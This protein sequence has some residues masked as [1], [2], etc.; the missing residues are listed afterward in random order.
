[1]RIRYPEPGRVVVLGVPFFGAPDEEDCRAFV[2]VLLDLE[3]VREVAI[4]SRDES[5]EVRFDAA[6]S[7]ESFGRALSDRLRAPVE[8]AAPPIPMKADAHGVFRIHRSGDVFST[9]QVVSEIPGRM[10]VRNDRLFRHTKV[11]QD[12]ERELM[13]IVG[14]DRFRTSA[15]AGSLLVYYDPKKIGRNELVLL[16]DEVLL[17]AEEHPHFDSNKYELLLCSTAV[18]LAAA[19]QWVAPV[20]MVPAAA[21]FIYCVTP[22]FFAAVGV[23]F[24]ERRLGVDVLDAIVAIMCLASNQIF[25]GAVL[26]WCLAFGRRMLERAREDS[27]RRLVQV[28]AKQPRHAY[29]ITDGVELRV[30]IDSLQ[31]G[32]V[33][34]VHTGE[35]MPVDGVVFEGAAVVDQ[36]AL[37]GESV[38]VEKEPGSR[39]FASTVVVGGR[40]FVTV[41]QAGKETTSARITSILNETAMYRLA[42]QSRGEAL[43]DRAVIPTLALAV[44]AYATRGLHP[45]VA[46]IN[47]DFGTGIRM[48][49]PLALLSSLTVCANRGILVKD[50]RALEE[51]GA[52]D[53]V[54]FDKTGTLTT[55]QPTVAQ[56]HT[57]GR[58]KAPDILALAAAAERRLGHPIALAIVAA[59]EELGRPY[60]AVEESTYEIGYGVRVM[61]GKRDVRVGSTR[62]L[63]QEDIDVAPAEEIEAQAHD[64][65]HTL[66]HVAV[67]GVL[68]GSIEL[69]PTLR[70][71][72]QELIVRLREQGISQIA[73]IS[74]DHEKPTRKLGDAL[75][76]DRWF[77]E[78]LPEDKARY[79]ELLQKEGRRVCFVGDGINDAIALKR[80]NVSVS[81]RGATSVATDTAQI[82]LM[83][84]N[85]DKLCELIEIARGLERNVATS[86]QMIL[87]PN[88]ACIAGAFFLNFGVMASVVAN[89][90]AAIA[91]LANGLRP[92][93]MQSG[94]EAPTVRRE[95]KPA[96]I[97]RDL[98]A[99]GPAVRGAAAV[100]LLGAGIVG[101]VM[102]G[103]PGW[104]LIALS[105]ALLLPKRRRPK[106]LDRWLQ[107]SAPPQPQAITAGSASP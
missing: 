99:R 97:V 91:A 28:F 30:P 50:G 96:R 63:R 56:V 25:A 23:L 1:M 29:L 46:V 106:L 33:V 32:D 10:R 24:G 27:R 9:S 40:L 77:A 76:V 103:I 98:A 6:T 78:V 5:A 65:G 48:A 51:M 4:R 52:I 16:L 17:A 62:Y 86:W 22:T 44:A 61:S 79:V 90:V 26:A 85:L 49:A 47:C 3:S 42:S 53:T 20:L 59:F 12:V 93:R 2:A 64:A 75:G 80:A 43:A 87:V 92:L 69:E 70:E 39:V 14:I 95:T 38:P 35:M 21:L 54:L 36:H 84:E 89:N 60:P 67:N 73:I 104:P 71:G 68:A 31:A 58:R 102:P 34:A 13:T 83:D 81:I 74:G 72:V 18:V 94:T 82:V 19:G 7:P 66:V 105:A 8:G 37:T 107:K 41:E 11:C 55:E 57:Y 101:V 15:M 45:A 100:V 88:L